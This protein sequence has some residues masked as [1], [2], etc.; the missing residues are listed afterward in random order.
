MLACLPVEETSKRDCRYWISSLSDGSCW[1]LSLLG[2]SLVLCLLVLF[3]RLSYGSSHRSFFI[4]VLTLQL[5]CRN[6]SVPSV[7]IAIAPRPRIPSRTCFSRT[8][9]RTH[10]LR[11][12]SS[13][14]FPRFTIYYPSPPSLA[15]LFIS[16][17][18]EFPP[19]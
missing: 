8:P 13:N 5:S 3:S 9:S 16:L 17:L 6:L 15:V 4:A 14:P 2:W 19:I 11:H 7:E 18:S 1:A 12:V 10:F